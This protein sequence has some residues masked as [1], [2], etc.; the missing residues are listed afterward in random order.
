[1]QG[2]RRD[3]ASWRATAEQP[4]GRRQLLLSLSR[5]RHEERGAALVEMAFALPLL[6]ILI[7]AMLDLGV[8]AN[9]WH[10]ETQLASEGARLAA[11][12]TNPG[13]SLQSYIRSRAVTGALRDGGSASLPNPLQVC[14]AFPEGENV[15]DPVEVTVRTTFSWLPFVGRKLSATSIDLV[16]RATMRLELAPTNLTAGCA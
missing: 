8:A 1:M 12:N 5:R 10:N 14:I 4:A 13:P 7:L 15:G 11:V 16:G 3:R 9:Y 6:L 2:M